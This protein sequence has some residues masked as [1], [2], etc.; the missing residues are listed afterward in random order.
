M[1]TV[2]DGLG[3]RETAQRM[4]DLYEWESSRLANKVVCVRV[5]EHGY[6]E[7]RC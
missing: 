7:A 4:D 5:A 2:K 1:E 6:S 3:V